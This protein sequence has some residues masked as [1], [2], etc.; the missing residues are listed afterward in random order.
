MGSKSSGVFSIILGVVLIVVGAL[1]ETYGQMFGGGV[2]G[3]IAMKMGI[4][5]VAGGVIQM[6]T[7]VPRA[8]GSTD[9]PDNKPS[10][11]FSGAVNT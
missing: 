4:A 9:S 6:L 8:P 11:I 5:M 10:Y 2:W 7:P 3:P 1:G